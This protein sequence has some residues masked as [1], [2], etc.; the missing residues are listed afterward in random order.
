M[1]GFSSRFLDNQL[2][3][4]LEALEFISSRFL[5]GVHS[6]ATT[7][8]SSIDLNSKCST[9]HCAVNNS[10]HSSPAKLLQ[11]RNYFL[12]LLDCESPEMFEA[13]VLDL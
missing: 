12:T 4:I 10:A 13:V 2:E 11:Q 7:E 9:S 5:S 8:H 6:S 1:R 3:I